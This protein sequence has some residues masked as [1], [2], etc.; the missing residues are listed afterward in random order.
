MPGFCSCL[1][2]NDFQIVRLP[3]EFPSDVTFVICQ[4]PGRL[5]F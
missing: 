5:L 2:F 4:E 3:R 1:I